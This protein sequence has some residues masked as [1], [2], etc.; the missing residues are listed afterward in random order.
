MSTGPE[1]G[2][3][4]SISVDTAEMLHASA[5]LVDT[6]AALGALAQRAAMSATTAQPVRRA[7]IEQGR[8]LLVQAEQEADRAADGLRTAALRY[9]W[10]EHTAAD[11]LRTGFAID[12]ALRGFGARLLLGPAGVPFLV[13]SDLG[14][15][16]LFLTA[17][18]TWEALTT[19]RVAPQ[20]DPVVLRA[21]ALNLSSLDDEVRGY[22]VTETPAELLTEDPKRTFGTEMIAAGLAAALLRPAGAPLAV[23]AGAGRPV[24]QPRSLTE[25][26]DRLPDGASPEGQVRVERYDGAGGTR[27]IVYI[28]GTVTFARDS[29]SEPFDLASNLLGVGHRPSDSQRAVLQA[30][31]QAGVGRDEPVLFVG[32]SQGALNAV[33]LAEDSGYRAGGVVQFGGPTEQIALPAD[34]PVLAVEHDQDLVPVLGGVA[35]GGAAGLNRVVVRRSLPDGGRA[36]GLNPWFPS[37]EMANYRETLREAEVSGSP[38]LGRFQT[39]VGGFLAGEDGTATRYRADRVLPARRAAGGALSAPAGRSPTA[40]GGSARPASR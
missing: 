16:A 2:G 12:A 32:H 35:A 1:I 40:V 6:R 14:R 27:W 21:L 7:A 23:T 8:D 5:V 39:Q 4:G 24:R 25:L 15:T 30:M 34:V 18:V 11:A 22:L 17:A 13:L 37:H 10:A 19:G 9:G 29:G 28:A 31:Q 38:T 33:R 3:G 36:P 20:L 26:A